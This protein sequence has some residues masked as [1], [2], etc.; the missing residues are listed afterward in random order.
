VVAKSTIITDPPA[1]H[2]PD[3]DHRGDMTSV[4]GEE[5]RQQLTHAVPCRGPF[6]PWRVARRP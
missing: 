4:A 5:H 2:D 6:V 3:D 1:I